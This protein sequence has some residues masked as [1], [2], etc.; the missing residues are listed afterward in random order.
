MTVPEAN[1]QKHGNPLLYLFKTMW[2]YCTDRKRVI[3]V[4]IMFL[5]VGLFEL[6]VPPLVWAKIM[7]IILHRG[8]V[9]LLLVFLGL[10]LIEPF[11]TWSLHGPAR[12]M[13]EGNAF[14]S[15]AN[16]R[17]FL[18]QGVM[19]LPMEWHSEHH[20][21]DVIDKIEKGSSALSQ[22]SQ[23]SFEIIYAAI[24]LFGSY[25]V[26]IYFSWPA[27][28]IVLA[29]LAVSVGITIH[30]DRILVGQYR[31]LN[32]ADNHISE[33]IFD[34]VSNISTVIILRVERLVYQTIAGKIDEPYSLHQMSRRYT[35]W[36]WFLTNVCC[37]V[38]TVIVLLVY[39]WQHRDSKP[40]DLVVPLGLLYAYL[41]NI[42]DV[43]F[44]FTS[45]YGEVIMRRSKVENAEV[46]SAD[47]L[48]GNLTNHVLPVNWRQLEISDLTFSY[49]QEDQPE[50]HLDR[51]ALQLQRGKRVALVG[52]S[53]S[54]KTTILK[55]IRGLHDPD[56]LSLKVDGEEVPDGFS[57]IARAIALIPQNAE[58]FT[59]TILNNITIGANHAPNVVERFTDMACIT[60]DI[61]KLPK[62]LDSS[63]KEKG[64]NLS[65]GQQQRLALA[66]GL[67]ACEDK[68]II[69]LD[70]PT[71]SQDPMTEATIFTNIFRYFQDRT[72][73]ASIHR[74][75]LL[76]HFDQ[77]HFFR[78]GKL[79][80]SG[81]LDQL[82]QICPEFRQQWEQYHATEAVE[83]V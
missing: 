3:T 34:A 42:N 35:E 18:L 29:M 53:G 6:I 62:G 66:R 51:I 54:G 80:A 14:Q 5:G 2:H 30:F 16:Y 32:Q 78:C 76:R 22:F 26:L 74:L 20:S 9:N 68:D 43:F 61:A 73:V 72:I 82:L 64:V 46:L 65:G 1:D 60:A 71:S 63:I 10:M 48:P 19:N 13:E 41:R 8:V 38:M 69:L 21:G 70:E 77:I 4:Y 39:F 52:K 56:H 58:I 49:Q 47:F 31:Q 75:H 67:L 50:P 40:G 23:Y 27:A 24:R 33:S 57:G 12:V 55:L 59:T 7:D 81:S 17:K 79:L 36:K 25:L 45:M 28:L 37:T 11:L 44:R 83:V 15:A